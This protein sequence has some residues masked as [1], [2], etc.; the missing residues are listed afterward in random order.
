MYLS[1]KVVSDNF[2]DLV[3]KFGVQPSGASGSGRSQY[4]WTVYSLPAAW[5]D[6]QRCLD[7]H[8]LLRFPRLTIG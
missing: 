3:G 5:N 7:R 2:S 1:S 6:V 8:S 4:R